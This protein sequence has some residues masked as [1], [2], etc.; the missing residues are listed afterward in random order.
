MRVRFD[1]TASAS[2]NRATAARIVAIRV[3]AEPANAGG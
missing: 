3:M 1:P 2:R